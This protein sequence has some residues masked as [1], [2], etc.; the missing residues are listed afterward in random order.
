MINELEK[1][2][3][4][5][6]IKDTDLPELV[7][8]NNLMWHVINEDKNVSQDN[9]CVLLHGERFPVSRYGDLI[10]NISLKIDIKDIRSNIFNKI[11][12]INIPGIVN[13][14]TE[15]SLPLTR[16]YLIGNGAYYKLGE[17]TDVVNSITDVIP[18]SALPYLEAFYYALLDNDFLHPK[19]KLT[20]TNIFLHSSDRD[21]IICQDIIMKNLKDSYGSGIIVSGGSFVNVGTVELFQRLNTRNHFGK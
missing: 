11:D 15:Y 4:D 19:M 16:L 21:E 13:I 2:K 18:I 10:H 1:M 5:K 12:I 6:I 7:P 9:E 17:G 8:H 3:L 20:Y 14:I